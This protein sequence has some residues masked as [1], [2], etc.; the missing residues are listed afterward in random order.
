MVC[1]K[2]R[3]KISPCKM[4]NTIKMSFYRVTKPYISGDGWNN[5]IITAALNIFI[6]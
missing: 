5:R 4:T 2:G 1:L 6:T 3:N